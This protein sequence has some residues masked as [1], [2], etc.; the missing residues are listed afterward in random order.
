MDSSPSGS[1]VHDHSTVAEL[2]LLCHDLLCLCIGANGHVTES[3]LGLREQTEKIEDP[4]GVGVAHFGGL[5][6]DEI[7]IPHWRTSGAFSVHLLNWHSNHVNY[8]FFD[9]LCVFCAGVISP[10]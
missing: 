9:I 8:Q 4:N 2:V 3:I 5:V 7:N 1:P 10:C 6:A